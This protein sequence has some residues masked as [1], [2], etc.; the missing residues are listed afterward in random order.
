LAQRPCRVQVTWL[1]YP[2][3]TGADFIDYLIADPYIVPAGAEKHYSERVIRLPHCYQPNDRKR[4]LADP[5]S[6]D[7]YGLPQ[8]AFVFCSFNQA[9]KIT[10][11]VFRRWMILLRRVP[12]S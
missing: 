7:E 12:G 3:T 2:G 6:R 1:G 11:A 5:R 8:E 9:V 4:P 10:P